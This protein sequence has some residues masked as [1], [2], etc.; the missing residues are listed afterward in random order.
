MVDSLKKPA[1]EELRPGVKVPS[2]ETILT[3][4]FYT[5]D[6]EEMAKMDISPN[7]D[8]LLAILEEFRTDYNR[9]HFVRD[10]EFEQ[11]WDHIDGETRQLFIE[12]LERSCTAEFSGFLLYK[13]LGRRLKDKNPLLAE[14]FNLMSRDEARH[15]GFLNKAMSDFN[16]SLDLGFLTK[17]HAYT[18]FKPKFIFYATYL[19]E[20]IGYWRYITIFRHL[21]AHPEHRI[22]PIFRFFENWCQ[23]ENRHG[24]F[25]D[26]IMR[27]Q[28]HILNDWKAKLWCRFF[29]L[30]VFATMYLNDIQRGD[31][32][33]AL[34]LDAREYDIHVIQKTNETSA[35]VFPVILDVDNPEF[36]QRLD[37]CIQN[38]AKLSEI[39]K[40]DAPK[41]VKFCQKLPHYLSNAWQLVRL[42]FMKPIETAPMM[43]VV[44]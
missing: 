16:L 15:A 5:T 31:F 1:F 43:E 6:F 11:S 39:A 23:D 9:H 35:R 34:G 3:P 14:C 17:N 25:F 10:A 19:S 12:F 28:P 8:E 30:S 38:N 27:S 29:L 21:E 18:F 40:S 22:Y 13:E 4:R 36:Y 24:D 32:Y 44:R 41:I 7:E 33:A 26:A 20:K 42:Y 2:K 37:I